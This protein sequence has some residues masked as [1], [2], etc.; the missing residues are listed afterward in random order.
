MASIK[1]KKLF[2]C[3]NVILSFNGQLSLINLISE[4]QT[5]G[6]PAILPKFVILTQSLGDVGSYKEIIEI[7][8]TDINETVLAKSEAMA[9]IKDIGGNNFIATFF[10]VAFPAEGKYWIRVTLDNSV[11]TKKEEDFVSIKKI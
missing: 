11:V 3:E 6:L 7:V 4:I 1:L 10:N 2:I 5:K 8:S 9:E